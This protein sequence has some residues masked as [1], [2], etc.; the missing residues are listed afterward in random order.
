MKYIVNG[1][2]IFRRLQDAIEYAN[3]IY[4]RTGV[5]VSIEAI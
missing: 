4:K 5:F 2:K 3:R 1:Q